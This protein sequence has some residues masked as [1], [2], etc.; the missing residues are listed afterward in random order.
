MGRYVLRQR[1]G[2][3]R[4]DLMVS[5]HRA[6]LSGEPHPSE[7]DARAAADA[8]KAHTPLDACY[9]RAVSSAGLPCFAL[10]DARGVVLGRSEA[11]ASAAEMETAIEA[12]K[13]NGPAA[14]VW[15]A[16]A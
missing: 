2:Q 6:I 13:A 16:N 7:R 3:F 4:F 5:S 9:R 10:T 1:D 14:S 15:F 12:V 8:A 11:F